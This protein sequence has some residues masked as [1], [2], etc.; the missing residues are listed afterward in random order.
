[1]DTEPPLPCA[2]SSPSSRRIESRLIRT[3][4]NRCFSIP[5][6]CK[7]RARTRKSGRPFRRRSLQ[8]CLSVEVVCLLRMR[9]RLGC[10]TRKWRNSGDIEKGEDWKRNRRGGR[11]IRMKSRW[12]WDGRWWVIRY[13]APSALP[14]THICQSLCHIP[15]GVAGRDNHS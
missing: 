7:A 14:Y 3:K 4:M 12:R 15:N 6:H 10:G 5:R 13:E 9:L 1:M 8:G 11:N 2:Y